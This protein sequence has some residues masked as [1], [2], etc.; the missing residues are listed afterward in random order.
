MSNSIEQNISSRLRTSTILATVCISG[1]NRL[2]FREAEAEVEPEAGARTNCEVN[3]VGSESLGLFENDWEEDWPEGFNHP[4][5]A[6]S[7][8]VLAL[9]GRLAKPDADSS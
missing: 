7:V 1:K 5:R 3:G 9:V 4:N 6:W 2:F 8:A